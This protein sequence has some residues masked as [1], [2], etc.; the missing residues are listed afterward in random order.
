MTAMINRVAEYLGSER[1]AATP[2]LV[3]RSQ[4][5]AES[6]QRQRQALERFIRRHP[7][8]S[9]CGAAILGATLAWWIK[10]K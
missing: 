3:P 6:L 1:G 4:D 5:V 2:H 8:L 9:V 10:R 7:G